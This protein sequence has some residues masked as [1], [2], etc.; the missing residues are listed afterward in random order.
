MI[1]PSVIND[2]GCST[3]SSVLSKSTVHRVRQKCRREAAENIK[4]ASESV[5]HWDGKLLPDITGIYRSIQVDRLP[6]LISS[7]IDGS[8]Q[9]LGIPK[10]SS[11]SGQTAANAVFELLK[12]WHC[13][14]LVV[15]MCFDT[16]ASNTGRMNGACTLL[17]VA[18]Q[19]NL[20]RMAF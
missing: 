15:G 16:T 5:V 2:S 7:L 8:T 19:Q 10:L 18:R 3:S 11:A 12:S 9:L 13:D 14:E 4:E 20:L 1:L 17:E 6:V